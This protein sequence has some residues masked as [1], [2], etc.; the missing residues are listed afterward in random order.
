MKKGVNVCGAWLGNVGLSAVQS[1]QNLTG[2]LSAASQ[3]AFLSLER[4]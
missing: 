2:Q 1:V 3:T 4:K